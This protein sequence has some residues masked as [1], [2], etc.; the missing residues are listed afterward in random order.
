[1]IDSTLKS[2]EYCYY[3]RYSSSS[4]SISGYI[5]FQT[6]LFSAIASVQDEVTEVSGFATGSRIC[7]PCLMLFRTGYCVAAIVSVQHEVATLSGSVVGRGLP[8]GHGCRRRNA[9]DE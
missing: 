9:G 8:G 7:S 3:Y 5:S 2:N 4:S 1:M 6:T